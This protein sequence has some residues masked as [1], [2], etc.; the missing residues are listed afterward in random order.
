M[1]DSELG[2]YEGWNGVT[3]YF[4]SDPPPVNLRGP[5]ELREGFE[6]WSMTTRGAIAELRI[7]P[8][9]LPEADNR[10]RYLLEDNGTLSDNPNA[11][12]R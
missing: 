2:P 5:A 8:D 6:A 10:A 3:G 4:V 1:T 7:N 9:A 12:D 11:G